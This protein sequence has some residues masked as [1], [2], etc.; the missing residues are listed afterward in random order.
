MFPHEQDCCKDLGEVAN[1]YYYSS[2]SGYSQLPSSALVVL[3][4]VLDLSVLARTYMWW[5]VP[6]GHSW[7]RY[8]LQVTEPLSSFSL[9]HSKEGA[10]VSHPHT[11]APSNTALSAHPETVSSHIAMPQEAGPNGHPDANANMTQTLWC[12]QWSFTDV[13]PLLWFAPSEDP[14]CSVL[15]H[16]RNSPSFTAPL[17]VQGLPATARGVQAARNTVPVADWA[18]RT[19]GALHSHITWSCSQARRCGQSPC[20]RG[21]GRSTLAH[22]GKQL[23]QGCSPS[24]SAVP[25]LHPAKWRRGEGEQSKCL[26]C[27]ALGSLLTR[28]LIYWPL[29]QS[30]T[31]SLPLQKGLAHNLTQTSQGQ[32]FVK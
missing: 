20:C 2:E 7:C 5:C 17:K 14:T 22:N 19:P 1:P 30:N 3:L 29:S 24:W 32:L 25:W 13:P 12:N 28:T 8:G 31:L 15:Q 4:E 26:A 11:P 27:P 18:A 16:Q 23:C 21:A 9:M 10:S 6:E